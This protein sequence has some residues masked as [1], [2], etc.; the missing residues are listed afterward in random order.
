MIDALTIFERL[1]K[2]KKESILFR[3]DDLR[4]FEELRL[5][6]L[7]LMNKS[8]NTICEAPTQY[9][10]LHDLEKKQSIE[11][12]NKNTTNFKL[13]DVRYDISELGYRISN[14]L[15]KIANSIT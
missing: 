7:Y 14:P 3:Y 4:N 6:S 8:T 13:E 9:N 11:G 15:N 12:V 2:Q 1:K 5:F 10:F